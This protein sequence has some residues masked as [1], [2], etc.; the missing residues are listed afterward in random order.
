MRG[1]V[2]L[3]AYRAQEVE[4]DATMETGGL[5]VLSDTFYPGWEADVDGAPTPIVRANYFARG[6]FVDRGPHHI[7]FRYRPGSHR[8]GVL[9][10]ALALLAA[11]GMVLRGA[12]RP[13]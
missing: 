3:S 10:S 2:V 13:C 7:V 8:A 5:V 9:L 4:L 1:T 11:L 12:R 6:V